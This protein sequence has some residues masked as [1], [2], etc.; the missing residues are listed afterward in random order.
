MGAT[1]S[2]VVQG[3]DAVATR[4]WLLEASVAKGRVCPTLSPWTPN[5]LV[6]DRLYAR[7]R[8]ATSSCV[9]QTILVVVVPVSHQAASVARTSKATFSLVAKGR[10]A[11]PTSALQLLAHG[12]LF[13]CGQTLR[14]QQRWCRVWASNSRCPAR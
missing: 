13:E 3:T 4:A 12:R 7:T 14:I 5:A 10:G 9:R 8:R 11:V 2:C 1:I 6:P